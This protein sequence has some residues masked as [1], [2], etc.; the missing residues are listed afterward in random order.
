MVLWG[1]CVLGVLL[2]V[3]GVLCHV[4]ESF[5]SILGIVLGLPGIGFL[6]WALVDWQKQRDTEGKEKGK[7]KGKKEEKVDAKSR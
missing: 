3:L 4:L 2:I 6:V 5:E 7:G 1:R